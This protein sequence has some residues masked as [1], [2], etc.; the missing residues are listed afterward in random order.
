MKKPA[1]SKIKNTA[2]LFELLTR[3]VAADTIKGVEKSPAL[4]IIREFFKAE[5][6]LAKELVLYQTLMT[7]NYRSSEKADYLINTV[8]NLRSRLDTQKIQKAKYELVK[9]IKKHY[10]LKSF[11]KTQLNEYKVLASIYQLFE[12]VSYNKITTAVNSKFT[13]LEHITRKAQVKAEKNIPALDE[14]VKQSEDVRLLTYKLMVDNFNNKYTN[15]LSKQKNILKEYINNISNT[16]ALKDFVI[17]EGK[18]IAKYIQKA[19]P[20]VE[21]QVTAIKLKEV[22]NIANN[23]EKVKT[24]KEHHVLS[25]LLYY[26]LLKELK[27]AK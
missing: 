17:A 4:Q 9:E 2:I 25:L 1:H 22:S 19:L 6:V 15:L 10:E 23:F 12:G 8:I 20:Q 13:V 27:N 7:E 14:Y 16:T 18:N 11:F 5:S 21:D 26:E 3:Q 24:I